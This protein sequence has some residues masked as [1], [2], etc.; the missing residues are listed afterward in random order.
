MSP[1]WRPTEV[2]KLDANKE[3]MRDQIKAV[4]YGKFQTET[5]CAAQMGWPRQRLNKIV[6]GKKEPTASELDAIAKATETA[7]DSI[8]KI[9]LIYWSPNRR[10]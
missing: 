5:A 8:A 3:T 9:F 1:G 6:Q 4:I 7:I 10:R 2:K